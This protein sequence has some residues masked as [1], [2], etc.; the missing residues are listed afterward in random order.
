M[1]SLI[2]LMD[3]VWPAC[4]APTPD[5]SDQW[6]NDLDMHAALFTSSAPHADTRADDNK[7]IAFGLDQSKELTDFSGVKLQSDIF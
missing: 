7:K 2:Q 1:S 6:L 5:D 3:A 4:F